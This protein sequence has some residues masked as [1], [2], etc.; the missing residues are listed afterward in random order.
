MY[1]SW[2]VTNARAGEHCLYLVQLPCLK[3]STIQRWID[4][5][6]VY[7]QTR[8]VLSVEAT[9]PYY[10]DCSFHFERTLDEAYYPGLN[11]S[12]LTDRSKDQVVTRNCKSPVPG[13][14]DERAVLLLPQVWLWRVGKFIVSAYSI[15]QDESIYP[16]KNHSDP[17]FGA[18]KSPDL[19][20]GLILAGHVESFEEKSEIDGF[21]LDPALDTFENNV[22]SEL[23]K[24]DFYVKKTKPS[25]IRYWTEKGFLHALSDIRSELPMIDCVLEQ[26]ME[27]LD[28]LLNDQPEVKATKKEPGTADTIERV[29]KDFL[30]ELSTIRE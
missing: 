26:Q 8:Q 9:G 15:T 2:F 28:D 25:K 14:A 27:V 3:L 6:A 19:H 7:E 23:V 21:T 22:T 24:V 10:A 30:G 11:A 1:L 4:T 5:R 17:L 20:L 18:Q 12:D 29:L 13:K 16:D